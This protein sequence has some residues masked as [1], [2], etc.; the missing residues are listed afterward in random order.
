MC[1]AEDLTPKGFQTVIDIDLVGTFNLSKACLQYLKNSSDPS[2]VNIT[3]T[4]QYKALPFQ[5]HAA[6]AKAGIDVMTQTLG[7]E[8]GSKFNIRV[9]GVAPGPIAGTE[10]GPT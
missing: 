9:N 7:T 2:I 6:A 4:L 5:V 3:A 8:W 10:G 1:A